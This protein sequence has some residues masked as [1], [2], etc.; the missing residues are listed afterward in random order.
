MKVFVPMRDEKG[1]MVVN[2]CMV[3]YDASRASVD[4]MPNGAGVSWCDEVK[5]FA[6]QGHQVTWITSTETIDTCAHDT[7]FIPTSQDDLPATCRYVL[8]CQPYRMAGATVFAIDREVWQDAALHTRLFSFLC[9]LQRELKWDV[10]HAR[11]DLASVFTAV[12]TAQFLGVPAVVSYDDGLIAFAQQQP[13][14]WRWINRHVA[15][16][17]VCCEADRQRLIDVSEL[18]AKDIRVGGGRRCI[19]PC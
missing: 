16:A 19:L 6:G 3:G 4:E 12:Y 10:I 8:S 1:A 5:G 15:G 13:F 2:M 18:T 9:L 17:R 7:A 14:V 11:G